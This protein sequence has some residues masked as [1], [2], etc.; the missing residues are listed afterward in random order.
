MDYLIAARLGWIVPEFARRLIGTTAD[1][2]HQR[3]GIMNAMVSVLDL[4]ATFEDF[5]G[6]GREGDL[7]NRWRREV[8]EPN[9]EIFPAV[10]AWVDPMAAHDRLPGLVA[11]RAELRAAAKR[12][13]VAVQDTA[14]LLTEQLRVDHPIVWAVVQRRYRP[15]RRVAWTVWLLARL[16]AP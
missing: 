2:G 12:A 11:R 8:V 1:G 10:E 9:A 14:R 7:V 4:A 16:A 15:S 6:Q 3:D 13:Q 5:A